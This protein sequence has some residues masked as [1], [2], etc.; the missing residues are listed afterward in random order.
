MTETQDTEFNGLVNRLAQEVAQV[1]RQLGAAQ[2]KLHSTTRSLE[3]RTQELIEARAALSLLHA[4]LDASQDGILAMGH[5]GRP[6][7][8][9]SRFVDLWGIPQQRARALNEP[10]LLALQMAQVRDPQRFLEI[11]QSRQARP[12]EERCD[13]IELTDGRVLECH[14]MPQR[15]NGR[16]LGC[17]S[18]FRDVTVSY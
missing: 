14:V 17:V 13:R 10:A 18:S 8:F 15:T 3:M 7:H 5:F 9:N 1:Q 4:T 11:W 6:M 2:Q 12:D 16:R